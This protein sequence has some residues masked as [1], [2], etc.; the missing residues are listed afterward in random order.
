MVASSQILATSLFF[1]LWIQQQILLPENNFQVTNRDDS[2]QK[3][4][5]TDGAVVIF[6][7]NRFSKKMKVCAA[8]KNTT[9]EFKR[10][11]MQI[12]IRSP[13]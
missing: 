8:C 10:G 6:V 12:P 13:A 9:T 2:I 11:K 7:Q 4:E 1:N 5:F 3:F